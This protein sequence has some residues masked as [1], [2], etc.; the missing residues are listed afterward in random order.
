M[1]RCNSQA[2][3]GGFRILPFGFKADL[4]DFGLLECRPEALARGNVHNRGL[5]FEQAVVQA[6]IAHEGNLVIADDDKQDQLSAE[7]GADLFGCKQPKGITVCPEF[8]EGVIVDKLLGAKLGV[9]LEHPDYHIRE[10]VSQVDTSGKVS[11]LVN[12]HEDFFILLLGEIIFSRYFLLSGRR[13]AE[14]R[15]QR[16]GLAAGLQNKSQARTYQGYYPCQAEYY[17]HFHFSS[18]QYWPRCAS[19]LAS[20]TAQPAARTSK[21]AARMYRN[22]SELSH[23]WKD[24]K[25]IPNTA[26]RK[27]KNATTTASEQNSAAAG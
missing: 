9:T 7:A 27:A 14:K 1:R 17:A 20:V 25:Y 16:D 19:A 13:C 3:G 22:F 24:G 8:S 21:I 10:E 12:K 5:D 2:D 26:V 11:R 18:L 4:Y 23:R 15:R 6:G